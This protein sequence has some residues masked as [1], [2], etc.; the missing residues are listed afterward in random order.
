MKYLLAEIS[1]RRYFRIN[2]HFWTPTSY[3]RRLPSRYCTSVLV[4]FYWVMHS[5]ATLLEASIHTSCS[6]VPSFVARS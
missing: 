4:H 2:L 1:R 5:D 6:E 3:C